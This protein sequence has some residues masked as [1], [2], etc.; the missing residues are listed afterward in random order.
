VLIRPTPAP[1]LTRTD[2]IAGEVHAVA[3]IIDHPSYSWESLTYDFSLLRL[4]TPSRRSPI[5]LDNGGFALP[6]VR[7]GWFL[8]ASEFGLN[9]FP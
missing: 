9:F 7:S 1:V 5:D 2:T 8:E 6:G 3:Q 4:A